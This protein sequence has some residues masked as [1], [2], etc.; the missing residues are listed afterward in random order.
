MA[1]LAS[2]TFCE[3]RELWCEEEDVE[4]LRGKPITRTKFM[5]KRFDEIV[6]AH[7]RHRAECAAL[8]AEIGLDRAQDHANVLHDRGHELF[9]QII[10][11][12]AVTAEG[13]RAKAKALMAGTGPSVRSIT[14]F[15]TPTTSGY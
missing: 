12:R 1:S 5:Q 4:A 10:A 15:P 8:K 3:R 13:V 9:G 2:G 11:T 7:D 14:P 6:S